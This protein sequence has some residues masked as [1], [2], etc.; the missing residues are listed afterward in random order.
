MRRPSQCGKILQNSATAW[1]F[2]TDESTQKCA[3]PPSTRPKADI[4]NQKYIKLVEALD[5]N[6]QEHYIKEGQVTSIQNILFSFNYYQKGAINITSEA[7]EYYIES[8]F[9]GI[10]TV[11]SNQQSAELNKNQKPICS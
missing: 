10:Y 9:D 11:M 1:R 8:P 3:K 5:G 2:H 6:R 7:G 4:L